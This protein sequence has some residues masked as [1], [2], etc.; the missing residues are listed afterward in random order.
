[1]Q[2][3]SVRTGGKTVLQTGVLIVNGDNVDFEFPGQPPFVVRVRFTDD[4]SGKSNASYKSSSNQ[5][6]LSLVNFNSTL[7]QGLKEPLEIGKIGGKNM[8][9]NFR[10]YALQGGDRQFTFTFYVEG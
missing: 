2:M 3:I 6:N 9:F 7:G 4:A 8:Q 10:V 5:F 1:M